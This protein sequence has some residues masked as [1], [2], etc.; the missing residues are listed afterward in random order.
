LKTLYLFRHAKS[1]WE[2]FSSDK[3]RDIL[4]SGIKKTEK[5]AQ[6]LANKIKVNEFSLPEIG[7]SSPAKRAYKTA[8]IITSSLHFPLEIKE[9]LYTFS[10]QDLEK[11]V[12]SFD[13]KYNKIAI[14]GHNSAFTDFINKF[15][16]KVIFNLPT[17]AVA[18]IEFKTDS[19]SEI[20]KGN[21]TQIIIPKE[22]N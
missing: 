7:F 5:V 2:L 11:I 10:M 18:I 20:S 3:E 4:P 13:N 9:E 14:F 6:F 1:N 22:L 19:W 17:S 15:G 8:K 21:T 16:N 12:K